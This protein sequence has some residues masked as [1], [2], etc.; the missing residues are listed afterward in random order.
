MGT[1]AGVWVAV[2]GLLVVGSTAGADVLNMGPGLTS[3]ETVP[4]GNANNTADRRIMTDR[5]TGYG[6]VGYD[7]N[8]GKYE[9]TA[10]Q[11]TEFLNKVAGVDTYGLY[12][13][14]MWSDAYGCKIQ[15][16]GH[17]WVGSPYTYSVAPSY[18]NRP[19]NYVSFWDGCRFANWLHNGQPTGAEDSSTT[20]GGAYT[21]TTEGMSNNTV[22][23]NAN[24]QWAVTSE[25]EWYKAAYYDPN[26][27]GGAGYWL[28]P[29]GTNT[30]PGRNLSETTNPGNNV[31]YYI[32]KDGLLIGSPYYR[33]LAGEFEL[34]DSPY[35]TFDQ[36]GNVWEWNEAVRYDSYRCLRGG[37]FYL[38]EHYLQSSTRDIGLPTYEGYIVGLRVSQVP[39]PATIMMVSF[40]G[41]GDLAEK[42]GVTGILCDGSLAPRCF[43]R[44]CCEHSEGFR[45]FL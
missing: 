30:I 38:N 22:T 45:C 16:S 9:V 24:W 4:I 12:N 2:A 8:V 28:Y 19:V 13:P 7:Y 17:G 18:A 14:K 27:A 29:T 5:T 34:S 3:L 43:C 10:G 20:E 25:D 6:S 33:T 32:V 21:L 39:E 40:S 42:E 11:Y 35:G 44:C 23:R 37:S 26:K 41:R 15:R 36:G 1:R 31:N